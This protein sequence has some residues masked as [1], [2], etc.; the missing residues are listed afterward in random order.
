MTCG[1]RMCVGYK[2]KALRTSTNTYIRTPVRGEEPVFVVTGRKE[3]VAQAKEYILAS[4]QHFTQIRAN[5]G[6]GNSGNVNTVPHLQLSVTGALPPSLPSKPLTTSPPPSGATNTP[7]QVTIEVRVPASLVGLVIGPKG[8]TIK[9]IQKQTFTFI[10]TPNREKEPV[11]RVSGLPAN[12]EMARLEIHSHIINRTAGRPVTPLIAD[13]TT[14]VGDMGEME[15]SR[16]GKL[17]SLPACSVP[18]WA[19]PMTSPPPPSNMSQQVPN[20][21]PP[22]VASPKCYPDFWSQQTPSS[23]STSNSWSSSTFSASD[24]FNGGYD[25]SSVV[26]DKALMDASSSSSLFPMGMFTVACATLRQP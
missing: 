20:G 12:V 13:P 25:W 8:S 6:G 9:R 21:P 15:T 26:G 5:R 18:Q 10:M 23:L 24:L 11:F 17:P 19:G 22:F 4:A 14:E 16:W 7:G 3:G 2:I 1:V